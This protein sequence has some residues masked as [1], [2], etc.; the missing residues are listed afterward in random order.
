MTQFADESR[1]FYAK[2]SELRKQVEDQGAESVDSLVK[3]MCDRIR[4]LSREGDEL[5][6]FT[7]D[8]RSWGELAGRDGYVL[9]RKDKIVD[10]II[11]NIN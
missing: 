7:S 2:L 10:L 8:R 3:R 4:L 9:V 6:F 11:R 1:A 5:C